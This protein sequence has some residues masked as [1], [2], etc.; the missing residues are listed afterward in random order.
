[1][2]TLLRTV[3]ATALILVPIVKAEAQISGPVAKPASPAT[4]RVPGLLTVETPLGDVWDAPGGI[5]ILQKYMPLLVSSPVARQEHTRRATIHHI[6]D[7]MPGFKP[8]QL[9]QMDL[10]LRRIPAPARS[11]ADLPVAQSGK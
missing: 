9:A 10:E 11:I 7:F 1:M 6:S 5:A 4:V 2:A 3:L 8:E